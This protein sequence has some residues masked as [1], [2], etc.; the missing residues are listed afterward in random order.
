LLEWRPGTPL[1]RCGATGSRTPAGEDKWS[2]A[3]TAC[4]GGSGLEG[5]PPELLPRAA[6]GAAHA[7]GEQGGQ[8]ERARTGRHPD[9]RGGPPPSAV[10]LLTSEA[11]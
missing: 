6:G 4:G 9:S 10:R 7:Q 1:D 8:S 5:M 2:A 3:G 11:I